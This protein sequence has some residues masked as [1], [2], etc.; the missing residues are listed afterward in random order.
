MKSQKIEANHYVH[1]LTEN[2]NITK[3]TFLKAKEDFTLHTI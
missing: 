2:V 3:E 1:F